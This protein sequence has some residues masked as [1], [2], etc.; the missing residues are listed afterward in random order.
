M[1]SCSVK[2]PDEYTRIIRATIIM[3]IKDRYIGNLLGSRELAE[4]TSMIDHPFHI[5]AKYLLSS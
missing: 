3:L 5:D 1:H 2:I 4:Q